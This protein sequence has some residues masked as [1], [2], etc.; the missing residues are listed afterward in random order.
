[1]RS[2]LDKEEPGIF[3][4]DDWIFTSSR[5]LDLEKVTVWFVFDFALISREGYFK[6]V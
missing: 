1:M 5:L 4:A 6:Q 3:L 2:P